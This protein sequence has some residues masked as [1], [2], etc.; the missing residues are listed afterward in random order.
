MVV[1]VRTKQNVI[2]GTVSITKYSLCLKNTIARYGD[3][4]DANEL[5][6]ELKKSIT[7]CEQ[8]TSHNKKEQM[9][10]LIPVFF[11]FDF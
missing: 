7:N 9:V 3:V 11:H 6:D 2:A 5:P 8:Q 4:P 1:K 10:V